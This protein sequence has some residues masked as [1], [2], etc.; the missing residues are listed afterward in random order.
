MQ[1]CSFWKPLNYLQRIVRGKD[2]PPDVRKQYEPHP[3]T[4]EFDRQDFPLYRYTGPAKLFG[5]KQHESYG[6]LGLLRSVP[7]TV[8]PFAKTQVYVKY[9]YDPSIR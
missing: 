3:L 6:V 8:K 2:E 1:P 4:E 5:D 9:I 7:I